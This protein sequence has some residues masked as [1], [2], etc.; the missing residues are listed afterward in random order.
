[1]DIGISAS[2]CIFIATDI[3]MRSNLHFNTKELI[4]VWYL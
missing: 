4:L 2:V 3:V 1:M